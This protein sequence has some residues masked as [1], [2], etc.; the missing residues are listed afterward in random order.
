MLTPPTDRGPPAGSV[1]TWWPK[2]LQGNAST[3]SFSGP[4]RLMSKFIWVKSRVVV[5]QRVAVFS[6][7]TT[8]PLYLL[9]LTF[10][11]AGKYRP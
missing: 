3:A 8:L 11:P 9:K 6:I 7:S 2:R 1:L 10:F 4:N 5:P